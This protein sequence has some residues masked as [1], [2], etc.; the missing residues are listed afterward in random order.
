MY[1]CVEAMAFFMGKLWQNFFLGFINFYFVQKLWQNF[2]YNFFHSTANIFFTFFNFSL[3]GN[4]YMLVHTCSV[5]QKLCDFSISKQIKLFFILRV[6]YAKFFL[7]FFIQFLT[8]F[9]HFQIFLF[10]VFVCQVLALHVAP[11]SCCNVAFPF[12]NLDFIFIYFSGLLEKI[13]ATMQK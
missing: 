13:I 11:D 12:F 7:F 9:F 5:L 6:S 10:Q 2:F 1:T 8:Y 3:S 4:C